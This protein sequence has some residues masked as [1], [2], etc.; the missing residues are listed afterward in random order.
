MARRALSMMVSTAMI[1]MGCTRHPDSI[2]AQYVSPI[3]YQS[4]TCDQLNAEDGRL[5]GRIATVA[6][7]QREN[8]NADAALM[9][10]GLIIF[11]PALFGLAATVDRREE[12]GRLRGEYEAVQQQRREKSCPE[13]VPPAVPST[14]ESS[15]PPRTF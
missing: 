8:A 4:W 13:P 2:Q 7:L 15:W 5:R 14:P 1:L 12:L 11:W 6:G 9:T 10:V 3:G